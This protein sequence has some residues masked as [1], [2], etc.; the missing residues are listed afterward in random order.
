MKRCLVVVVV[1][2]LIA[3]TATAGGFNWGGVAKR[4]LS[5]WSQSGS[6]S[7]GGGAV[8]VSYCGRQGL[9]GWLQE[10]ASACNGR[11]YDVISHPREARCRTGTGYQGAIR[12]R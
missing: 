3:T 8:G 5:D 12:C 9:Q 1:V 4:A 11:D 10:A 6:S 7:G 2:L